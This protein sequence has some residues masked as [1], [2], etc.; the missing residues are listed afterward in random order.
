MIVFY[1]HSEQ[2]FF[3]I[4]IYISHDCGRESDHGTVCSIDLHPSLHIHSGFLIFRRLSLLT[5]MISSIVDCMRVLHG[6][7][8]DLGDFGYGWIDLP[9]YVLRL[10]IYLRHLEWEKNHDFNGSTFSLACLNISVH[11][12]CNPR[13]L[14]YLGVLAW[15]LGRRGIEYDHVYTYR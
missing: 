7:S 10:C 2:V 11:W 13:E 4:I 15:A 9:F 6:A 14:I 1:W 3:T 8:G 5:P 12:L